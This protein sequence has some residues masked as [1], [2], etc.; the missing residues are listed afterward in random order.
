M[1][2]SISKLSKQ[3]TSLL[4]LALAIGL[5]LIVLPF[6]FAP[7]QPD[8]STVWKLIPDEAIA[9]IEVQE[10]IQFLT[11]SRT[12]EAW[13]Q[14]SEL[15]Y[16]HEIAKSHD[17][18]DSL[19][20]KDALFKQ[21]GSYPIW[22]SAHTT[23]RHEVGFL[24]FIPIK[25]L[26]EGIDQLVNKLELPDYYTYSS[27]DYRDE[28]IKEIKDEE[29]GN[30]YAFILYKDYLIGSFTPWL[31]EDVIRAADRSS[32]AKKDWKRIKETFDRKQVT[33]QAAH[34]YLN[35]KQLPLLTQ[36]FWK[37]DFKH[38]GDWLSSLSDGTIWG[39]TIKHR[40][41]E[42]SGKTAYKM[43]DN[44]RL[45][46]IFEN[47]TPPNSDLA[48]I[49]PTN[50]AYLYRFGFQ[51][52]PTFF[53]R[54][55][56]FQGV[57][58][59]TTWKDYGFDINDLWKEVNGEIALATL[60]HW[61]DS[62]RKDRLLFVRVKDT[63]EI[64]NQLEYFV[65][66]TADFAKGYKLPQFYTHHL[67]GQFPML[68]FPN[69]A[70]GDFYGD[71]FENSYFT[72]IKDYLVIANSEK[73]IT[74]LLQSISK[75]NVL[76]NAPEYH[77]L[78][79]IFSSQNNFGLAI[80]FAN[81]WDLVEDPLAI[82]WKIASRKHSRHLAKLEKAYL[83]FDLADGSCKGEIII[84]NHQ[85]LVS[86]SSSLAKHQAM[87]FANTLHV[88][89][90]TTLTSVLNHTDQ[91]KELFFQDRWNRINL[92]SKE[93]ERLWYVGLKDEISSPIYQLDLYNNNKLQYL[94]TAGRNI[95][96][97]DRLGRQVNGF[98]LYC[99]NDIQ[100]LAVHDYSNTKQYFFTVSDAYG[101]VFM[102]NKYGRL[103]AG[104]QPKRLNGEL[105]A[106]VKHIRISGEDFLVAIQ[107]NGIVFVWNKFGNIL[108]G[109]PLTQSEDIVDFY[110]TAGEQLST[111]Y[112]RML[113]SN[114]LFISSNFN[115]KIVADPNP[116]PK[117]P[118]I[119]SYQLC[120]DANG[121]S[122]FLIARTEADQLTLFN[123]Q[124]D[125]VFKA[126]I[127]PKGKNRFQYFYF[128]SEV[129]ILAVTDQRKGETIL[130]HANGET[131]EGSP[132]KSENPV[133]VQ[134]DPFSKS[135]Y[136]YKSYGKLLEA[137]KLDIQ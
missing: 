115:G 119:G 105:A 12:T 73:G 85:L 26:P 112:I 91:S 25:H 45:A 72:I 14:L 4:I 111:S 135:Y 92:L 56:D 81:S 83:T 127:N 1:P 67:I 38:S 123:S 93:G 57:E 102:F 128:N 100:T 39:L 94:F 99:P 137:I 78:A 130:Y 51:D 103:R 124:S 5:Y 126:E 90:K 86:D 46:A 41:I 36:T 82:Q 131:V 116:L 42:L 31:V 2:L 43:T 104:W 55:Y 54:V 21:I 15:P 79:P 33:G 47:Q 53:N 6:I 16:F 120:R 129:Q 35:H 107:K 69:H 19:H 13:E 48:A 71:D 24:Q 121:S 3:A 37:N 34:V 136:F 70:F 49:L 8:T 44:K 30:V 133:S 114:G 61:E 23:S 89:P 27:R 98:P 117:S 28:E 68:N 74:S 7:Y 125:Q 80:T 9:V 58:V 59:N 66:I 113:T 62:L 76:T 101:Q 96:L 110:L 109:F 11:D 84:Q 97:F 88:A 22:V 75:N 20:L 18:L 87:E 40:T 32:F 106:P 64:A 77:D 10:P 52:G 17:L 122:Q 108:N 63:A 132:F 29:S 134:Y 50:T 118:Y 60:G 65:D 95:Y